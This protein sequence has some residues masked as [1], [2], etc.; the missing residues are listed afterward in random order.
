L[1]AV[2]LNATAVVNV[3]GL[4]WSWVLT[5]AIELSSSEDEVAVVTPFSSTA[6]AVARAEAPHNVWRRF[7]YYFEPS[8]AL[9]KTD[10]RLSYESPK[11]VGTPVGSPLMLAPACSHFGLDWLSEAARVET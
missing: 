3:L 2:E 8:F 6:V 10:A 11:A 7:D 9:I 1:Q 4:P 5:F